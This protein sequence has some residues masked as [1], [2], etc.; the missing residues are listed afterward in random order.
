MK[1]HF[2]LVRMVII[3]KSMNNKRGCGEKGTFL[4]F[5]GNVNWSATM[6]KSMKVLQKTKSRTT[7]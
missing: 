3:K 4:Y 1:Y 2:M 6:E 5:G 7:I